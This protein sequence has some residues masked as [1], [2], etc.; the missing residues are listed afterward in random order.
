MDQTTQKSAQRRTCTCL[1]LSR[2]VTRNVLHI[3][4]S[5][6]PF[7][8]TNVDAEITKL[9][10]PLRAHVPFS[11]RSNLRHYR[12]GEPPGPDVIRRCNDVELDPP[13]TALMPRERNS[14][15][16]TLILA[17]SSITTSLLTR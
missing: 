6:S 7:T 16:H 10:G 14:R 12:S 4:A 17:N 15:A 13:K 2:E 5:R 11:T 8:G 1:S 9:P 3:R